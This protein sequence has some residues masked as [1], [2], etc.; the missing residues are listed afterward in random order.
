MN[1]EVICG[2]RL[3]S[4]HCSLTPGHD[5]P[6]ECHREGCNGSWET[7]GGEFVRVVRFPMVGGSDP[8]EALFGF[9]EG[10]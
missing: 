6:H 1:A 7:S 9:L 10:L 4:C 3:S 8:V 2:A 5:G